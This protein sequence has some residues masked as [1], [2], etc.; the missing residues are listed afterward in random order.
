VV[1]EA[2]SEKQLGKGE[3]ASGQEGYIR[4]KGVAGKQG[5]TLKQ[6]AEHRRAKEAKLR[7]G[8]GAL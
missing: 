8:K 7:Y 5:W 2:A 4:D 1:N 3:T 6:F